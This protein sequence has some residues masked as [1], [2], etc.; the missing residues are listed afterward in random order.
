MQNAYQQFDAAFAINILPDVRAFIGL[1]SKELISGIRRIPE[2]E[3]K[4]QSS[5]GKLKRHITFLC[6][7]LFVLALMNNLRSS[8]HLFPVIK[9]IQILSFGPVS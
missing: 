5:D 2:H 9:A 7:S 4:S 6:Y 1:I 8:H 3:D